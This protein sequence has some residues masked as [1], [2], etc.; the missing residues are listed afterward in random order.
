MKLRGLGGALRLRG[1]ACHVMQAAWACRPCP[2]GSVSC[3]PPVLHIN[4]TRHLHLNCTST[5]PAICAPSNKQAHAGSDAHCGPAAAP[6]GCGCVFCAGPAALCW[7]C[8]A[9]HAALCAGSALLGP[10]SRQQCVC[11]AG[12]PAGT[13]PASFE[14]KLLH[15]HHL[16]PP[17]FLHPQSPPFTAPCSA[18]H[19]GGCAA[20]GQRCLL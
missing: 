8:C 11:C 18:A 5:A 12:E 4:R 20:L 17:C 19:G 2:A 13:S 7:A 10:D 3:Y 16:L 6:R 14:M 9:G 1:S 15:T